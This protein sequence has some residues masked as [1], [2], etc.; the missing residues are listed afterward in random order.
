MYEWMPPSLL[1]SSQTSANGIACSLCGLS[2]L[3]HLWVGTVIRAETMHSLR[4]CWDLDFLGAM[5]C[6]STAMCGRHSATLRLDCPLPY[7]QGPS[8]SSRHQRGCQGG[9]PGLLSVHLHASSAPIIFT[10]LSMLNR[11]K[12]QGFLNAAINKTVIKLSV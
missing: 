2:S 11:Q 9:I 8:C 12:H 7:G 4:C 10:A 6:Q 3:W 5:F 1:N